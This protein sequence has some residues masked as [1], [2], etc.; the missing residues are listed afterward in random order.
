MEAINPNAAKH[1]FENGEMEGSWKGMKK[2]LEQDLLCS[3]L[4]GR[5]SYQL[6]KYTKYGSSGDCASVSLDGC[7]VKKF[8]FM[9]AHAR[10]EKAGLL[11]EGMHVWDVPMNERDD[12]E[13]WEFADALKTF[14]NQPIELSVQSGNPI[15]RMFAIVDRRVG[16]RTLMKLRDSVGDQPEWLRKLYTTRMNAEGID[17]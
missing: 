15:I 12:Y 10:L 5:V 7:A 1:H 13:L 8:G 9:Y 17:P 16:K 11:A 2:R 4:R 6:T 14:R 3:G